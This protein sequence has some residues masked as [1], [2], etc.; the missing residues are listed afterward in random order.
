MHAWTMHP[1]YLVMLLLVAIII[2]GFLFLAAMG[3]VAGESTK[4]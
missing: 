2:A 3:F 4:D 1:I